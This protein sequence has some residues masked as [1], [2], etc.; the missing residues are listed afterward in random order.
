M[1]PSALRK[2]IKTCLIFF[3]PMINFIQYVLFLISLFA[4]QSVSASIQ[5]KPD[6]Y[7]KHRE[8]RKTAQGKTAVQMWAICFESAHQMCVF[9]HRCCTNSESKASIFPTHH[10]IFTEH[11]QAI[12][13]TRR[14][15]RLN[16]APCIARTA[17]VHRGYTNN[18]EFYWFWLIL[19]LLTSRHV[20]LDEDED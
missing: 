17:A 9:T 15:G 13:S 4:T 14:T 5:N 8:R 19:T 20:M 10:S 7:C 11:R 3:L 6:Q 2:R 12:N 16:Y 1:V 18:V